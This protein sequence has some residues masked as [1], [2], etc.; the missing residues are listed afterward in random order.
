MMDSMIQQS[1]DKIKKTK[2]V[3]KDYVA[4]KMEGNKG[5]CKE[6]N[7]DEL[8][9]NIEYPRS[10]TPN[11]INTYLLKC[12]PFY[13]KGRFSIW[14]DGKHC[15]TRTSGECTD[16][17]TTT[18]WKNSYNLFLDDESVFYCVYRKHSNSFFH[19]AAVKY[20][21]IKDKTFNHK[22]DIFICDEN[23][24]EVVSFEK[25]EPVKL[26]NTENKYLYLVYEATE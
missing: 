14:F 16:R 25:E 26:P 15:F 20:E 4:F 12:L 10:I 7:R 6:Y 5:A 9:G 18:T 11:N 21:D 3:L 13:I 22:V 24:I 19:R 8:C 2:I 1:D 23:N 17:V